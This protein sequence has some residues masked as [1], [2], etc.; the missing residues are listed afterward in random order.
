MTISQARLTQ[1]READSNRNIAAVSIGAERDVRDLLNHLDSIPEAAVGTVP[2]RYSDRVNSVLNQL[3][4]L[5]SEL[6]SGQLREAHERVKILRQ[7]LDTL[8]DEVLIHRY[9]QARSKR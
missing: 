7:M 5:S 8:S 4:Q 2:V 6:S 9:E 3:T 1:I